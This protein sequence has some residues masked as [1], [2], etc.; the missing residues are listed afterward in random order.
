MG[1]RWE[2]SSEGPTLPEDS[3]ATPGGAAAQD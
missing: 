3:A 1:R 2:D